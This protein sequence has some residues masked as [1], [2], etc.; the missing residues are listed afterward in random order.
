MWISVDD[1]AARTGLSTVAGALIYNVD[2]G[3]HQGYDGTQW[4]DLY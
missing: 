4:Y 3:K 1:N 2:K